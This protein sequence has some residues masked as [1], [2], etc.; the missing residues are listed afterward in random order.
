MSDGC[1]VPNNN[2]TVL[3]Q[4]RSCPLFGEVP[5]KLT[6]EY[7]RDCCKKIEEHIYP[8]DI[9]DQDALHGRY[10]ILVMMG[11][12]T[13]GDPEWLNRLLKHPGMEDKLPLDDD[14][15]LSEDQVKNLHVDV[16]DV[17]RFMELQKKFCGF[18]EMNHHSEIEDHMLPP[19]TVHKSL[20]NGA[21]SIV[22]AV[23]L[24]HEV[25]AQKKT[26]YARKRPRADDCNSGLKDELDTL[27]SMGHHHHVVRYVGSYQ[28]A[29][30]INILLY[31]EASHGNLTNYLK[32]NT[33]LERAKKMVLNKSF[34]CLLTGLGFLSTTMRHKD[35]KPDNILI[36]GRNVLYTDFGSAYTF[37]KGVNGSITSRT[38]P[39]K[40]NWMYAAPEVHM[41]NGTRDVKTDLFSLGCVFAEI[42]TVLSEKQVADLH[43]IVGGS[44][45]TSVSKLHAWLDGL[46]QNND[47]SIPVTWCKRM[48]QQERSERPKIPMF[49]QE[50]KEQCREKDIL[51]KFFCQD[52]LDKPDN[53]L[54]MVV[55]EVDESERQDV[56]MGKKTT[57]V[58]DINSYGLPALSRAALRRQINE[59]K[60]LLEEKQE[61]EKTD[62]NERATALHWAVEGGDAEIVECLL[63]KGANVNAQNP[64]V[65][66]PLSWA[67][68]KGSTNVVDL[69]LKRNADVKVKNTMGSTALHLAAQKGYMQLTAAAKVLV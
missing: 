47:L 10:K 65:G 58:K 40:V 32:W 48:T 16:K 13:P 5:A 67:V 66:S 54:P 55:E 51:G 19:F 35:I 15:P 25:D 33:F 9:E 24:V 60:K 50:V 22:E 21:F 6:S 4:G 11:H 12:L 14:L 27:K 57:L 56:S 36:H 63:D 64:F 62:P 46:P 3:K 31:P 17:S 18:Y 1:E 53:E 39:G 49:V 59:V 29:R 45:G 37:T 30:R 2:T 7:W 26:R 34:G 52:C 38:A 28:H 8:D 68:Q 44:Y 23:E 43:E 69:L 42:I 41:L 61:L 20:G